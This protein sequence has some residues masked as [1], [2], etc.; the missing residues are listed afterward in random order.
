M[1]FGGGEGVSSSDQVTQ[2]LQAQAMGQIND[3]HDKRYKKGVENE[4]MAYLKDDKTIEAEGQKAGI[5][6]GK[7]FDLA[8]QMRQNQM[9][10]SGQRFSPEQR[11]AMDARNQLDRTA[12]VAGE[13]N[14]GRGNEATLKDSL[15]NPM[16]SLGRQSLSQGMGMFNQAAGME[17]QRGRENAQAEE[18]ARQ[19]DMSALM[20]IG[21]MAMMMSDKNK[22]HDVSDMDTG[23]ALAD[24]RG[25]DLKNWRYN[26]SVGL[27]EEKHRGPMAQDAPDSITNPQ[28]TMLN[29]HDELQ[30]GMGAI[31]ALAKKVDRIEKR[32]SA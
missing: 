28:K 11:A 29:L 18:A 31:Q 20:S 19:G 23:K 25:M 24:V 7:Q 27:G 21:S 4:L 13:T 5:Q 10:K 17:N 8:Q 6:A 15:R 22:K 30:L 26:K 12:L 1:C 14:R 2:M 32:V 9:A 16:M 3:D